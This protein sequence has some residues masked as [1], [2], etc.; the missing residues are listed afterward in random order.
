VRTARTL[1]DGAADDAAA[2]DFDCSAVQCGDG[3]TNTA[4][5]ESCD[6]G[7]VDGDGRADDTSFCNRDCTPPVCGDGIVNLAAGE[8]CDDADGG[9]R[10]PRWARAGGEHPGCRGLAGGGVGRGASGLD[11]ER[12]RAR[13]RTGRA[14]KSGGAQGVG[15]AGYAGSGSP[16]SESW[17]A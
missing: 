1:G 12:A 7:D 14:R 11:G 5:S 6:A 17:P 15:V 2:C 13:C 3:H 8:F 16:V 4:A 10:L 9:A